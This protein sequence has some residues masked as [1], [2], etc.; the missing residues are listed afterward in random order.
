VRLLTIR[1]EPPA[2]TSAPPQELI[3]LEDQRLSIVLRDPVTGRELTLGVMAS[4]RDLEVLGSAARFYAES[5]VNPDRPEHQVE[6]RRARA[7]RLGEA[8]WDA[9]VERCDIEAPD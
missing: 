9:A 5:Y 1:R 4:L 6:T 8:L 7:R 2:T 3:A